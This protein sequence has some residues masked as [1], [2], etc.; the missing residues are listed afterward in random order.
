MRVVSLMLLYTENDGFYR[1]RAFA[2]MH[3][4][5][6]QRFVTLTAGT[7]VLR[8]ID[9]SH[10]YSNYSK[11]PGILITTTSQVLINQSKDAMKNALL[12]GTTSS[13]PGKLDA[14][15]LTL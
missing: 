1:G 15:Q 11:L 6:R 8:D 7:A 10:G 2:T 5:K 12:A 3:R 14:S 4:D 13:W 9:A